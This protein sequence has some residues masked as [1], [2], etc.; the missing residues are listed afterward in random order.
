LGVKEDKGVVVAQ[1]APGGPADKAGL[2]AGDVITAF[3][4]TE[5][6]DINTFRNQVAATAP[7]A[8]VTLTV[9]RDGKQQQIRATLGE[10]VP[11]PEQL[12]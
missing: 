10:L 9:L 1:V 6:N 8:E 2:K 4:G 11:H 3:N 7:G 5:V 12:R